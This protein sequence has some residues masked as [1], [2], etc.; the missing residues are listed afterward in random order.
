MG[1]N[2]EKPVTAWDYPPCLHCDYGSDSAPCTCYGAPTSGDDYKEIVMRDATIAKLEA[3]KLRLFDL[4]RY[5]RGYLHDE[6]C[7]TDAEYSEVLT[8]DPI[9][10]VKRLEAYY[11]M[12]ARIT[13]LEADLAAERE[14]N[15]GLAAALAEAQRWFTPEQTRFGNPPGADNAHAILVAVREKAKREGAAEVAERIYEALQR[16]ENDDG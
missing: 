4:V 3:E 1:W 10:S 16:G 9:N 14:R 11:E 5:A 13:E 15:A 8:T 2:P 12:K 7:L 6:G